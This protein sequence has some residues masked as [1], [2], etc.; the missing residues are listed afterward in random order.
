MFSGLPSW[1]AMPTSCNSRSVVTVVLGTK[2]PVIFIASSLDKGVTS[3]FCLE[4]K[5]HSPFPE[6]DLNAQA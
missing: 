6:G 2:K 5:K 3:A 1:C 4:K